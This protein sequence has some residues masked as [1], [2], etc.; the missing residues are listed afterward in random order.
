MQHNIKGW[1]AYTYTTTVQQHTYIYIYSYI[2]IYIYSH[3]YKYVHVCVC[4]CVRQCLCFAL[5]HYVNL[6]TSTHPLWLN[7]SFAPIRWSISPLTAKLPQSGAILMGPDSEQHGPSKHNISWDPLGMKLFLKWHA[8]YKDCKRSPICGDSWV[9]LWV[10]ILFGIGLTTRPIL[11]TQRGDGQSSPASVASS[12]KA[13]QSH[14]EV[15]SRAMGSI[16]CSNFIQVQEMSLQ[17]AQC[18]M[19]LRPRHWRRRLSWTAASTSEKSSGSGNPSMEKWMK[20]KIGK[21]MAHHR[22]LG[23]HFL[24]TNRRHGK[25]IDALALWV[26]MVQIIRSTVGPHNQGREL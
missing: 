13:C 20:G 19:C 5:C 8:E 18:Q 14:V 22:M 10:G 7:Q 23:W 11:D 16:C 26:G 12:K 1:K 3:I 4:A 17:L 25:C 21:M 15:A 9:P 24:W 2:Y 6:S